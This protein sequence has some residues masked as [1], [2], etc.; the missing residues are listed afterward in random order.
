M[1]R[2]G[3]RS[4]IGV[5]LALTLSTTW[6]CAE[7][8]TAPATLRS[9]IVLNADFAQEWTDNKQLVQLLRGNCLIQ[10]GPTRISASKAVVWHR[11]EK[12]GEKT[13]DKLTVY[14]EDQVKLD[15]GQLSLREPTLT[16]ELTTE[17]GVQITFKNQLKAPGSTDAFYQRASDQTRHLNRQQVRQTQMSVPLSQPDLSWQG[18]SVPTSSGK[19]RIMIDPRNAIGYNITSEISKDTLPEEMVTILS[20]GVNVRVM[21]VDN[22]DIVDLSADNIVIWTQS[23]GSGRQITDMEFDKNSPIQVYLEGN[24]E[25]RSGGETIRATQAMYDYRN[26]KG[27]MKN[28][29]IRTFVPQLQGE[30]RIRA[31]QVRQLNQDSFHAQNAWITTSQFGHPGYRLQASDIYL[32]NRYDLP[33]M[34]QGDA[35]IDPISGQLVPKPTPWVTSL[36]N[37]FLVTEH[38]IPIF[39]AP[40]LSFPA[41]D[42]NIPLKSLTVEND[43]VF[44]FQVKS[45]WDLFKLTGQEPP[46]G[47]DWR[48]LADYLS[49]RGPAIGSSIKYENDRG[50]LFGIPGPYTGEGLAIYQ[51]DDGRDNLGKD[52]R[53]LEPKD[54]NRGRIQGRHQQ[55]LAPYDATF[56]AEVG[57]LSDRNYLEQYYENEFDQ[58][59][60]VETLLFLKQDEQNWS[61]SFLTR[62]QV[63][64]FE[65]T[66]QWLPRVDLYGLGEPILGNW[67]TWSSHSS[68]GYANFNTAEAP[69]DP[70]DLFDPI[71]YYATDKDGAVLMTRHQLEAPFELGA[72]QV[73]PFV[74]GEA[75][76]WS[77]GNMGEQV[78]RLV[79][80]AGLRSSLS[81]SRIFPHVFSR[82][83]GLNGLAHKIRFETEYSYTDSNRPLSEIPL[84]NEIDDNAQERFRERLLTNTFGGV[85]PPTFNPLFYGVRTGAGASVTA[86]WHELIDSQQVLRMGVHQRLQTRVGPPERRRIKDWMLLDLEASYFPDADEDNFGEDFGLLIGHYRWN[87]GPRTSLLADASYDLFDTAQEIWSFGVLSQRSARGSVYAGLRQVKGGDLDSQIVT[88]SYSYVMSPKWI[89]TAGTAYD[90]AENINRGQTF[91]ITRVGADFLIHT[92]VNIDRSKDNVGFAF[93]IEPRFGAFNGSNSQLGSLLGIY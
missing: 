24:I 63:N 25:I 57:F 60:D 19:T 78:D 88:A 65:Y 64:D 87:V 56:I 14:L 86:P 62:P 38:D 52:R 18:F 36:N 50:N 82:P 73:V 16:Q 39:Y 59:K 5:L 4:L 6:L 92:G 28:A 84:Y 12:L 61:W 7:E 75:A 83:L 43:S 1:T 49:D 41:E 20:G 45:E 22:F 74:M 76:Y 8:P 2:K 81:M 91:T 67:L 47:V 23:D 90:I 58:G 80:Q 31:A 13:T 40:R 44:G 33:W 26:R 21:G 66:T 48:L 93:S 70:N 34:G 72:F 30:V 3:Y 35:D 15:D 11:S 71:P 27:L 10:Q 53:S 46:R 89:S 77:E 9:P 29:E 32:Q 51:Y 68:A 55:Y 85:L 79:G 37:Q 17:A 42:P 69:T 54:K